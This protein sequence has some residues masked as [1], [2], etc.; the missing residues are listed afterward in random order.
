MECVFGVAAS[1]MFIFGVFLSTDQYTW[2]EGCL[3]IL[4][5]F[6]VAGIGTWLDDDSDP[7]L[8]GLFYGGC[9]IVLGIWSLHQPGDW[10][11]FGI[12]WIIIGS[13][14]TLLILYAAIYKAFSKR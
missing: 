12:F 7:I 8:K 4:A 10:Y 5:S 3:L 13:V 2:V 11:K 9:M 6:L 14:Y 1:I